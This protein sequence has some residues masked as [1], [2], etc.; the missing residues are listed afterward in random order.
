[1][2]KE[3]SKIR[4]HRGINIKKGI[5]C[6][7]P[8]QNVPCPYLLITS[9]GSTQKKLIVLTARVHAGETVGS[10]M[11]KGAIEYLTSKEPTAIYLR[12][13]FVF[14][15]VPMLNPDGVI[16]GNNRYDSYGNDLNRVFQLPNKNQHPTIYYLK[17]MIHKLVKDMKLVFYCDMHGH[18]RSKDIF[19]YGNNEG[20][21]SGQY[22]VFPLILSEICSIFDFEKCCFNV[23]KIKESTARIVIWKEFS[24]CNVFTLEASFFGSSNNI[25]Y[26]IN[27]YIQVGHKVCIGIGIAH[28]LQLLQWSNDIPNNENESVAGYKLKNI[29]K[30]IKTKQIF[31]EDSSLDKDY[32]PD[33]KIYMT[34]KYNAGYKRTLKAIFEKSIYPDK[35]IT[36]N[37]GTSPIKSKIEKRNKA[38]LK[39]DLT[40]QQRIGHSKLGVDNS[41]IKKGKCSRNASEEFNKVNINYGNAFNRRMNNFTEAMDNFYKL[42]G[43]LNR[44]KHQEVVSVILSI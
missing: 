3:L 16:L 22:K 1:L 43:I 36:T 41:L 44:K 5:L 9:H 15:I 18:G 29:C 28:K 40:S 14:L 38:L 4:P 33:M 24:L 12:D 6:N 39:I 11:M 25:Q 13:N 2:S 23:D 34:N 35:S 7:T 20:G 37:M 10:F 30:A 32:S 26:T 17:K 42:R 21:H 27:D 19:A 31:E 8:Y